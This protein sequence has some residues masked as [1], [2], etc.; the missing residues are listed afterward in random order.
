MSD[1][2]TGIGKCFNEVFTDVNVYIFITQARSISASGKTMIFRGK[3]KYNNSLYLFY[4]NDEFKLILK[5][6]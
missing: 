5:L 6:V 1:F 4:R 3:R 2:R